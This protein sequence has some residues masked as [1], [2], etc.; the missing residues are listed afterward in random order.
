M[1]VFSLG[2]SKQEVSVDALM[3]RMRNL[4]QKRNECSETE[5]NDRFKTVEMQVN[6]QKKKNIS[7]HSDNFHL[8][9]H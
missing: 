9:M 8:L 1:I 4:S 3:Q 2:Q 5:L 6:D 7:K